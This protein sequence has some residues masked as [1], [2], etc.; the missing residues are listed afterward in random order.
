[1]KAVVLCDIDGTLFKA[2]KKAHPADVEGWKA[3]MKQRMNPFPGVRDHLR[4]LNYLA[5]VVMLTARPPSVEAET[6]SHLRRFG[7]RGEL[8]MC[9]VGVDPWRFKCETA[10]RIAR[11]YRYAAAIDDDNYRPR[12]ATYFPA[13]QWMKLR[14]WAAER[15][16]MAICPPGYPW[17]LTT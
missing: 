6:R 2:S 13:G 9:P 12:I 8:H 11:G 7:W 16:L 10:D 1:M 3:A 14:K 17:E 4:E 5:T 15:A